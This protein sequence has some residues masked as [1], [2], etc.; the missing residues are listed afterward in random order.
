[1]RFDNNYLYK[2]KVV[3]FKNMTIYNFLIIIIKLIKKT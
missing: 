3:I 2:N 1:M